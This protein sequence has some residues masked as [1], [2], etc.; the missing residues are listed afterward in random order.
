MILLGLA[1]CQV[2]LTPHVALNAAQFIEGPVIIQRDDRYNLRYRCSLPR[3]DFKVRP[4]LANK[5]DEEAAYYFFIGH[6]SFPEYGNTIEIPLAYD[7]TRHPIPVR[8]E[9]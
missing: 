3:G 1:G 8:L 4:V 6:T 7:G 9:P 2:P 5:A